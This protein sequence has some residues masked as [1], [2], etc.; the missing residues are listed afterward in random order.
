MLGG[1]DGGRRNEKSKLGKSKKNAI[2]MQQ[3]NG[4]R[5]QSNWKWECMPK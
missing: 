4:E 1:G 2:T 5:E 3:T